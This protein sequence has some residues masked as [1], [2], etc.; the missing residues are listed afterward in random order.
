[1]IQRGY[2][3]GFPLEAF[4]RLGL[5]ADFRRQDF[6]GDGSVEPRIDGAIHSAGGLVEE[7][8]VLDY[9]CPGKRTAQRKFLMSPEERDE[10]MNFIL[11]SQSAAAEEHRDAMKRMAEFAK[12]QRRHSEQ[13]EALASASRDLV[14]VARIHARRLD[15]LDNLNP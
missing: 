8:L 3:A 6:D 10:L 2:C 11:Q 1:M 12:E 5:L 13:I 4:T 14:E 9:R 15:R 7:L